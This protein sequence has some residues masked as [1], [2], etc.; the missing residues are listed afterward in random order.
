MQN[1]ILKDLKNILKEGWLENQSRIQ[2][3][4][5]VFS[6]Q[7]NFVYVQEQQHSNQLK[8]LHYEL[9]AEQNHVKKKKTQ[10]EYIN[11]FINN[12]RKFIHQKQFLFN[13]QQ[14]FMEGGLKFELLE[15]L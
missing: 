14:Q 2:N 5:K 12:Y 6:D 13:I 10:R 4:Q 7:N 11:K 15:K 3:T 8:L 1:N 9:L